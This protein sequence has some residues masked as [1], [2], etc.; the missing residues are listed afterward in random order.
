MASASAVKTDEF[1]ERVVASSMLRLG[2]ITAEV[3]FPV[4]LLSEPSV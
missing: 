4:D 3:V 2:I 1:L